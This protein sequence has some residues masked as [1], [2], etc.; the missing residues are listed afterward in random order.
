MPISRRIVGA[1]FAGSIALAGCG[2]SI[3][4]FYSEG[5][6][7]DALVDDCVDYVQMA[8]FS[9]DPD[10]R[11]VWDDAGQD[12]TVLRDRCEALADT[13]RDLLES[14][15]RNKRVLVREMSTTDT[16]PTNVID[17]VTSGPTCNPN[18]TGVCLPFD[19]DVDCLPGDGDGPWFIE[20]TVVVMGEDEFDLDD[21]D[22]GL[23]CEPGDGISTA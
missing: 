20:K 18:Y 22:D 2:D 23:G 7:T 8:A 1:V 4:G 6:E 9:G 5:A 14:Y 21:D 3:P 11:R 12:A 10:M 17:D 16:A 19:E 15:A 13:D